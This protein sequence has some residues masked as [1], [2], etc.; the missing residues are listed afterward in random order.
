[1]LSAINTEIIVITMAISFGFADLGDTVIKESQT[2]T[3]ENHGEN[4]FE[5]NLSSNNLNNDTFVA[6]KPFQAN[7]KPDQTVDVDIS[8]QVDNHFNEYV[9]LTDWIDV[10]VE[11]GRPNKCPIG[12][13]R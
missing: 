8:L 2:F 1:M 3:L 6:I 11:E 9:D 5:L 13:T 12:S 7:I 10:E 4:T